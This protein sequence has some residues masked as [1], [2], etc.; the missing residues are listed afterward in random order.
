MGENRISEAAARGRL[1]W[2]RRT[3]AAVADM[4][5][6][7]SD[8]WFLWVPVL[9]AAG[10]SLYFLPEEE[11]SLRTS[12]AGVL[13]GVGLLALGWR[14]PVPRLLAAA[15]LCAA[16]GFSNAQWRTARLATPILEQ[17]TGPVTIK[18]WVERVELRLKKGARLTLGIIEIKGSRTP[19]ALRKVRISSRFQHVPA[20]GDAVEVR[21]ILRPVPGPVMPGA[22]DFA[23][24]AWFAGIGASGFAIGAPRPLEDP[25]A[26]T[27][28][29]RIVAG[30][31][32][33]RRTVD[34]RIRNALPGE[35]GAIASAL[36]TGERGL[37][38]E[39]TLQA[40]R[41]SGLA[42]MLAI[43]GLHMA[44]MAGTLFWLARAVMAAIPPLALRFPIKKIAAVL[45]LA[46]GSF[47][48]ALSGAAIATQRA[49]LMM[50]IL[51]LAVLLDRPAITLRN[52]ALAAIVVLAMFP[53]SLFDVSFQMS[54]AAA[55]ALVAVYELWGDRTRMG[56]S[57]TLPG[58]L[59]RLS[60][61]YIAGIALT[62]LV[63]SLAVAPFAA[64]HFHKLA[65][66]SLIANLA[67]MPLVGMLIMP[68]ALAALLLMP[69]G[70][71]AWPL[72]AMGQGIESVTWVAQA[73]SS[74]D[75]AVIRVASIPALSLATIVIGG[76]WLILWRRR[77]RAAGL[78]IAAFGLVYSGGTDR[79]QMLIF[80]D[81]ATVAVLSDS[82]R[83]AVT[84][85]RSGTYSL[86]RWLAAYADGQTA[87]EARNSGVFSCD[88]LACVATVLGKSVSL[89]HHPA[90]L[91]EECARSD[92]VVARFPVG[93]RCNG[94]RAVVDLKDLQR[95]GAHALHLDGQSI[96]IKTVADLRGGR[97]W[98]RSGT[99]SGQAAEERSGRD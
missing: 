90:A 52:V 36:T 44:L 4:L 18:A 83:L 86:E 65:Q 99:T 62:T 57:D 61:T 30:I 70:L 64:Y 21:A 42:H 93:R 8:R 27:L 32:G 78:L 37:I 60:A 53:E 85:G 87:K 92:I 24:K 69:L 39:P 10:I 82:G 16:L 25:P 9:F 96:V 72:Q 71:E 55:T 45:A 58:R 26:P 94:A 81:G 38:P 75:G 54:F 35:P 7:E 68:M 43:S 40:L 15:V 79:P 76:L 41:H 97:P 50:A 46:G 17:P 22:F 48:L 91:V 95:E 1:P 29:L 67:A 98:T 11:P 34:T 12:F 19:V 49:Y 80:R 73:V 2:G 74:L 66:Y 14:R 6:T 84:P 33:L 23:R 20:A 77:W 47:Y 3:A 31:A 56:Y 59:T 5:L 51:F 88:D 89:V 63:A 13:T 28:R